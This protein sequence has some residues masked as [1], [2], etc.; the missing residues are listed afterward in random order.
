MTCV[1]LPKGI[2]PAFHDYPDVIA[3]MGMGHDL[4]PRFH[5]DKVYI[6]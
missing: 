5:T 3:V 2:P 4:L 1:S 6:A